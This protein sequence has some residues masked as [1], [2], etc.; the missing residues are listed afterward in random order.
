M[1]YQNEN[2]GGSYAFRCCEHKGFVIEAHLH[3]YS[4]LFYC[5]RGVG[6]VAINGKYLQLPEKHF[7]E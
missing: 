7:L 1:Q 4:E 6:K 3:E 5:R 2:V